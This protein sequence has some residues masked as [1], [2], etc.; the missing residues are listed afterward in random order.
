MV[1]NAYLSAMHWSVYLLNPFHSVCGYVLSHSDSVINLGCGVDKPIETETILGLRTEMSIR[2]WIS[3][4]YI[5]YQLNFIRMERWNRQHE[6][7]LRI[8]KVAAICKLIVYEHIEPFAIKN[9]KFTVLLAKNLLPFV[10]YEVWNILSKY[11]GI[12]CL[13]LSYW[14]LCFPGQEI[15]LGMKGFVMEWGECLFF[16]PQ[17]AVML[18]WE[19][20]SEKHLSQLVLPPRCSLRNRSLKAGVAGT[21]RTEK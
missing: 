1:G 13:L 11:S 19:R 15:L 2:R 6:D 10:V 17:D 4:R 20:E 18:W 16:N 3:S 14:Y 8:Q 5:F 7:K 12:K 21:E 9:V